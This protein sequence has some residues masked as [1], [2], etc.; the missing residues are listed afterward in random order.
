MS[1]AA[2]PGGSWEDASN[3]FRHGA[4]TGLVQHLQDDMLAGR[5]HPHPGHRILWEGPFLFAMKHDIL[6]IVWLI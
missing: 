2:A 6:H 3:A 5:H 1:R 4:S